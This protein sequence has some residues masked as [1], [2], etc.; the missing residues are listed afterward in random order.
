MSKTIYAD[1]MLNF[2][3][4]KGKSVVDVLADDPG[5]FY[6]LEHAGVAKL[7]LEV[8]E[9]VGDWAA[10]NKGEARKVEYS[11]KKAREE[12]GKKSS[13]ELTYAPNPTPVS[14]KPA[15]PAVQVNYSES[16]QAWGTW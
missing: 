9:V 3:K 8:A 14:A 12:S 2:G 5:Y 7:D 15:K 10:K 4:Y 6:W 1:A 13:S 11:A 16:N